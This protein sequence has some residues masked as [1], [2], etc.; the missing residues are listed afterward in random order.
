MLQKGWENPK[1]PKAATWQHSNSS[2]TSGLVTTLSIFLGFSHL[3]LQQK[4][5]QLQKQ[6][7]KAG[8]AAEEKEGVI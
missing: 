8:K 5:D 4:E 6:P 2:N 3:L 7:L 1:V